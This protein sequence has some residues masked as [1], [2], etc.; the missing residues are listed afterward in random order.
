MLLTITLTA[1]I[2][3]QAQQDYREAFLARCMAYGY[4]GCM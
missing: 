2:L 3:I 1:N 4:M